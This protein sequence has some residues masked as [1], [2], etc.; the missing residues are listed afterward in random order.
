MSAVTP[1]RDAWAEVDLFPTVE[2]IGVE[3]ATW[4]APG[5]VL[6]LAPGS[7]ASL[8]IPFGIGGDAEDIGIAF[9]NLIE[10]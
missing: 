7:Q 9:T 10:W 6:P 5:V 3:S 8:A 1:W 2:L 4:L